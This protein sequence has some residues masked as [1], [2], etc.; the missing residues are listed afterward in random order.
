[1][2]ETAYELRD[3]CSKDI[4][5]MSKI[6][7]KIG[8]KEFNKCFESDE[9]KQMISGAKAKKNVDLDSI[10]LTIIMDVAAII[11]D[12]LS[13]CENDIYKLLS[14]LSGMKESEI[15]E[16]PLNTFAEIIIDVVKKDE[17]KDFIQV[18]S[19]LFK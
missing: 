16:L 1:M 4:F 7:S 11:L 18:V 8:V 12:N 2:K 19:K 6:I 10:G 3:L 14:G 17:F 5:P 13:K 9:V 15:A